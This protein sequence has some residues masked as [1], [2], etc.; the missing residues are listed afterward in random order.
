MADPHALSWIIDDLL[1]AT[2]MVVVTVAM[3]GV[4]LG[5]LSRWLKI[6]YRDETR[7]HIGP[8]SMR[9]MAFTQA[10]VLALFVLHGAEIWLYAAVYMALDAVDD[11]STALYFST[12]SY[13]AIGYSDLAIDPRWRL[14]GA[15]E[16]INGLLLLGW[17]T[18]F[19]VSF[20]NRLGRR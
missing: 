5:W 15:I 2:A 4:A 20:L 16:G 17:S 14:V 18:A 19:F 3:H 9:A 10:M 13:A 7:H 6:E 8:L 11:F 12:I 1:I